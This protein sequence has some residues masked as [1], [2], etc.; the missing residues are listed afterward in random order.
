MTM[1]LGVRSQE[2]GISQLAS[3]SARGMGS[4]AIGNC[5][6]LTLVGFVNPGRFGIHRT[7]RDGRFSFRREPPHVCASA[8][9]RVDDCGV[10]F[11]AICRSP[12][13]TRRTAWRQAAAAAGSSAPAR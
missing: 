8:R 5:D 10:R 2:S 12:A 3:G 1:K 6:G 13:G 7:D 9:R 4:E 11:P